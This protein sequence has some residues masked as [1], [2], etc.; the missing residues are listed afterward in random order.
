MEKEKHYILYGV[1]AEAERFIF[2]NSDILG[3]IKLCIDKNNRKEFYGIPVRKLDEINC[4]R[5]DEQIIVAAGGEKMYLEMKQNLVDLGLI[6]FKD[7]VWTKAFRRRIVVVNANCYGSAVIKYLQ[8]SPVFCKEYMVYPVPVIYL[9]NEISLNLLKNTDVYIHQDIREYNRI[10]YK[11][12]DAYICPQLKQ[13]V[14]NVCIPNLV[15]MG[16]WMFPCLGGLDRLMHSLSG[17]LN[18]LF[19]DYVLDEAVNK[20]ETLDE[21]RTF[22]MNFEIDSAQHEKNFNEFMNKLYKR[23]RNWDIKISGYIKRNYKKIPC[24]VDGDHPSKYVMKEVGRQ[25]ADILGLDDIDD[26]YYESEMGI[27][28]PILQDVLNYFDLDF[29]VSRELAK[30]YLGKRVEV[31][32]DDYIRAYLWWYHKIVIN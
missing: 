1:G 3:K 16:K 19:R 32:L 12:S 11:L 26:E 4:T 18:V 24:F 15:G 30:E 20:C 7:F 10:S 23:E 21:Y 27:R 5:R 17:A 13:G 9:N 31:E 22:W 29:V 8:L 14:K 6:E 28:V 25:V 2:C